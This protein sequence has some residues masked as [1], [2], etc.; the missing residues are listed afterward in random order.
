MNLYTYLDKYLN[1]CLFSIYTLYVHYIPATLLAMGTCWWCSVTS[2]SHCLVLWSVVLPK[3]QY[4]SPWSRGTGNVNTFTPLVLFGVARVLAICCESRGD[5]SI[6]V[7]PPG[8]IEQKVNV[9]AWS[10]RI[11]DDMLPAAHM[12]LSP[13]TPGILFSVPH[14]QNGR[15]FWIVFIWPERIQ[16]WLTH[17]KIILTQL[18]NYVS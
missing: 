4:Y 15:K 3:F 8:P 7:V 12:S 13:R 11:K 6:W 9:L 14:T 17:E 18:R 5:K 1:V 16:V 10:D 2:E